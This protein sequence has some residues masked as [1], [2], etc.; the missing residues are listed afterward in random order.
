MRSLVA[1]VRTKRDEGVG[2]KLGDLGSSEGRR[3]AGKFEGR[4]NS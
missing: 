4:R 3:K 2:I 1:E